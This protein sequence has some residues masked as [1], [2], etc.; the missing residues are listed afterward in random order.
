MS[1]AAKIGTESFL[2]RLN[3][4]SLHCS[5]YGS[6]FVR[7]IV[8][9]KY[10]AYAQCL[11]AEDLYNHVLILVFFHL[12]AFSLVQTGPQRVSAWTHFFTVVTVMKSSM[13]CLYYIKIIGTLWAEKRWKAVSIV[14]VKC[15]IPH[16]FIA[17]VLMSFV[18]PYY[19]SNDPQSPFLGPAIGISALVLWMRLTQF[20]EI[21]E[22]VGPLLVILQE[23]ID[24]IGWF[25]LLLVMSVIGSG[26]SLFYIANIG[27][28]QTLDASSNSTLTQQGDE[29]EEAVTSWKA[30]LMTLMLMMSDIN[31]VVDSIMRWQDSL[32]LISALAL[33]IFCLASVSILLLNVLIAM[34]GDCFDRVK[35]NEKAFFTKRKAQVIHTLEVGLSDR[36]RREIKWVQRSPY[37]LF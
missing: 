5:A 20:L 23:V 29:G 1:N 8:D 37:S 36:R 27:P 7:A 30:I 14:T 11:L 26:I 13:H 9:F 2:H 21:T 32:R 24:D 34:M 25:L 3:V 12:M 16:W 28:H 35:N 18:I 15:M 31:G 6:E 19:L 4:A 17:H 10:R 33:V 22:K